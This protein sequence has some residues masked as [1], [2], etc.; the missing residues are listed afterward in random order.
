MLSPSLDGARLA[1]RCEWREAAHALHVSASSMSCAAKCRR[2][3]N[4]TSVQHC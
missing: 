1:L 4:Y 2:S 3:N